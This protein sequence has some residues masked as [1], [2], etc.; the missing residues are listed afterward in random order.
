LLLACP[1]AGAANLVVIA[2]DA[3][4]ADHLG[5]YGYERPTS[6]AIDALAKDGLL[7]TNAYSPSSWTLP[8][9]VSMMT[10]L[11]SPEHGVWDPERHSLSTSAATL[12]S[13][14]KAHGY[15]TAAFVPGP[16][17]D[18]RYGLARGFDLYLN[19]KP[20]RR[21]NPYSLAQ[22]L[23]EALRWISERKKRPF[24]L[25]L[26]AFEPHAP[27]TAPR[28]YRHR[29]D[30]GGGELVDELG[31]D[32]SFT[33]AYNGEWSREWGPAPSEKYLSAIEL[34]R[35]DARARAH[36]TSHYDERIA[37]ADSMIA[38]LLRR[39]EDSGLADDTTVILTSDHGEELGERGRFGHNK[40]LW[41]SVLRVPLIIRLPR[42]RFAGARA[43]ESVSLTDLA[44]T[45]LAALDLPAARSF[46][47][48]SLLPLA[49]GLGGDRV[50]FSST[51]HDGRRHSLFAVTQGTWRLV[52]DGTGKSPRL[53]DLRTDPQE[54]RDAASARSDIARRLSRELAR[55]TA[56]SGESPAAD[57]M[58]PAQKEALRAAGYLD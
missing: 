1:T 36:V 2:L 33:L 48:K 52:D 40:A 43:P 25:F 41:N 5:C 11:D 54:T 21:S 57:G 15:E 34:V 27:Y 30:E 28:P 18:P 47:G 17:F 42:R 45:A 39:L 24:F 51:D 7:F 10:S 9:F 58:P 38:R 31:P 20:R 19:P 49:Q 55:R 4:R 3:L 22:V 26:Y 23:P 32:L 50:A 44:P 6:P 53:F 13:V 12:A 35:N 16:W 56:L 46:R 8:S 14:L 37:Y 29:F